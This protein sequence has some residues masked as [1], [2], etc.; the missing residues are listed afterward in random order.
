M[1]WFYSQIFVGICKQISPE[2][3]FCFCALQPLDLYR[4]E[5]ELVVV[6]IKTVTR[7]H[8]NAIF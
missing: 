7:D 2:G 6:Y 1:I 4:S 5:A 3:S 8:S